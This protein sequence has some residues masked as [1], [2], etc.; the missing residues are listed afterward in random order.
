[1]LIHSEHRFKK[2]QWLVINLIA[3]YLDVPPTHIRITRLSNDPVIGLRIDGEYKKR[4]GRKWQP[5]KTLKRE[6]N[7]NAGHQ[8]RQRK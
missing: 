3:E 8:E 5:F 1:M 2:T 7:Q 6:H 4:K